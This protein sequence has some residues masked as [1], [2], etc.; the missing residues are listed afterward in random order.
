MAD[1]IVFYTHPPSRRLNTRWIAEGIGCP[2]PLE[3]TAYVP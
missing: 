2:Y 1:E 3:V